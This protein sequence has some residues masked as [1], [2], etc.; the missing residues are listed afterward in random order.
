[1]ICP[2]APN[3]FTQFASF[4]HPGAANPAI[5]PRPKL[6]FR[7]R[8]QRLATTSRTTNRSMLVP[9]GE[10]IGVGT[11]LR[12]RCAV[13]IALEGDGRHPNHRKC[14]KSL[15]QIVILWLALGE[16]EPPAVIVNDDRNMIGIVKGRSAA[17]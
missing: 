10:L 11:G 4:L 6:T 13:G 3:A 15:F 2:T 12:M 16:T 17:V 5:S 9:A 14:G 8:H 1:M 7:K